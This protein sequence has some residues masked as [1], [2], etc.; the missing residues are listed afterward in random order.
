MRHTEERHRM[1]GRHLEISEILHVRLGAAPSVEEFVDVEN[2]HLV[3][4][5]LEAATVPDRME[6]VKVP[7]SVRYCGTCHSLTRSLF[8]STT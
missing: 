3:K 1:A 6:P 8:S 5:P 7:W 4:C 2:P